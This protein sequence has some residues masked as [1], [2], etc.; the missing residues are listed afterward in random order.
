MFALFFL[1]LCTDY[2]VV[3]HDVIDDA[4]KT[5]FLETFGSLDKTMQPGLCLEAGAYDDEG[6]PN[7]PSL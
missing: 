6:F 3:E 2:L 7:I 1:Q 4:T 5:D